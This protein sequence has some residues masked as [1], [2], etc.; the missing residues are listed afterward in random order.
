MGDYPSFRARV[1]RYRQ[2]RRKV[3]IEPVCLD[4]FASRQAG[5]VLQAKVDADCAFALSRLAGDVQVAATA[6]S[7]AGTPRTKRVVR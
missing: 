5:K 1:L 6:G 7:L 2:L 3:P 4:H